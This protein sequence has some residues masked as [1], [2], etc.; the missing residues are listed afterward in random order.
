MGM[1]ASTP[2]AASYVITLD[3]LGTL[4]KFREPIATQYIKVAGRCGL[5]ASLAEDELSK[6][7]KNSFKSISSEYPNY[8]KGQLSSPRAWWK[9]LV[10]DAFRQVVD[11]KEIPDHLGEELYSHFTSSAAYELYP[12][13]KP[14]LASM[15]GLK[16][17][18]ADPYGPNVFIGVVSNSD[19]R[20]KGILQSLG[21]RVGM[22][23]APEAEAITA[24]AQQ[25]WSEIMKSPWHDSFDALNDV[26]FL[27]TS[28]EADA[29]KPDQDIFAY[30]AELASLNY[31]S[32]IEQVRGDNEPGRTTFM[33]KLKLP[34]YAV[35]FRNSAKYIHIGDDF[36]KDYRGARDVTIDDWDAL[37]LARQGEAEPVENATTVT[38]LGEAATAIRIM[39]E[40]HLTRKPDA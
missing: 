14:F 4:Y 37:Y 33:E 15:R 25:E 19:P 9:T 6:A 31:I 5:K 10:N 29:E 20:V 38:D 23:K 11:E 22:T 34:G 3:A 8:G 40:Q 12:D 18:Y 26:D 17:Q 13:V 32:K 36:D 21:L 28:Y 39:A 27:V 1:S 16:Q 7:F 30:A 2:V 24:R 35:K